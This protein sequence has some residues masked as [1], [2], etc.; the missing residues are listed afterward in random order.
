MCSAAARAPAQA[1]EQFPVIS[2]G[3]MMFHR[4]QAALP[5]A[6][7]ICCDAAPLAQLRHR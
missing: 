3:V 1:F 7:G 2:D 4:F 6:A 5:V